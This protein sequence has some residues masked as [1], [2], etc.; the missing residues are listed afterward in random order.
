MRIQ[1]ITCLLSSL[2][3]ISIVSSVSA[4]ELFPITEPGWDF[5]SSF[6]LLKQ[7]GR[8]NE[9]LLFFSTGEEEIT[10]GSNFNLNYETGVEF[11][12]SRELT[13]GLRLS[14]SF[15]Q[16]FQSGADES[17]I[18]AA[19]N[20]TFGTIPSSSITL[21]APSPTT[22]SLQSEFIS[23]ELNLEHDLNEF[24]TI[25]AGFRYFGFDDKLSFVMRDPGNVNVYRWGI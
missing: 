5:S 16:V 2:L 4:Q 14:G 11:E 22:V 9:S 12:L 10:N 15:F 18:F 20:Y 17:G 21:A 13:E 24:I 19:G 6:L 3:I 25:L 23:S 7:N 8:E 1:R